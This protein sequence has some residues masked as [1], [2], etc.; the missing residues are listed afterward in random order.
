[1]TQVKTSKLIVCAGAAA[2]TIVPTANR[3]MKNDAI[4]Y[5]MTSVLAEGLM[6]MVLDSC[7]PYLD[8]I[9][10]SYRQACPWPSFGEAEAE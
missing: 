6:I 5:G 1:M 2:A 7:M 8:F 10:G 4:A 9:F 3:R